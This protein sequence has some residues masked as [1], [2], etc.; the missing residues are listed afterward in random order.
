[1]NRRKF[2]CYTTTTALTSSLSVMSP[3]VLSNVDYPYEIF[4][5]AK[6]VDI[7]ISGCEE[8]KKQIIFFKKQLKDVQSNQRRAGKDMRTQ[9]ST[10]RSKMSEELAKIDLKESKTQGERLIAG[11]GLIAGLILIRFA[12]SIAMKLGVSALGVG[13]G[14]A[15]IIGQAQIIAHTAILKKETKISHIAGYTRDKFLILGGTTAEEVL[16]HSGKLISKAINIIAATLAMVDI[17]SKTREINQAK[18]NAKQIRR[19]IIEF[20]EILKNFG[21]SSKR[22][23]NLK[24]HLLQSAITALEKHI[25]NT[26]SSNCM[27]INFNNTP[28]IKRDLS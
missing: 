6:I 15:L 7:P 8:I 27:N 2:I 3:N 25:E 22:W 1:M 10:L 19:K 5:I 18:R 4:P 9:V 21:G 23:G 14:G 12:P 16:T 28:Q 17:Y 24:K 26:Q 20:D 13:G 11:I